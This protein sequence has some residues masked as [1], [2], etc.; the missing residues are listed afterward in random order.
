MGERAYQL[1]A[2]ER[3]ALHSVELVHKPDSGSAPTAWRI[4]RG[5]SVR[6]VDASG[7]FLRVVY[8]ESDHDDPGFVMARLEGWA[9]AAAFT[10]SQ[11]RRFYHFMPEVE[12]PGSWT[13]HDEG[14][15]WDLYWTPLSPRPRLLRGQDEWLAE[16]WNEL[17]DGTA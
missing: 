8:E 9:P 4:S 10:R 17:R 16:F 6:V 2:D 14:H 15:R 3:V 5:L 7:Q 13:V 1:P 12:T 11:L